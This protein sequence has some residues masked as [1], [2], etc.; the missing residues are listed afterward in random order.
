MTATVLT[1]PAAPTPP[2]QPAPRRAPARSSRL[3]VQRAL[4]T[5][6]VVLIVLVQVYPLV[7]LLL[8]SFRTASDFAGGNPFALPSDL[9]LDNYSRA[10]AT[11]NLGLN[12]LNS[13]I[14]T[15]GA[16]ALIVVAGMMAAFA[17]QVLG[18]RLSGFVRALFLLGI[19]VPVQI[20][21]VP[22]FIDYSR[23][24]LLDTHLSMIIPL[25]AFALPMAVYLFSSFYE[26]I[27]REMYE[28]AS[29]DGAGPYR[30]FGQI[31]LP[32]SLNTI[33]TVVLVNSIFIWNDF[34]FANTFVLSDGLKTIPLGLQNYI[35]AMGNTDWTATFAAVCVTVTPLLLV[36]LV[37][38]KAMIN[39]LESG[40]T[41]G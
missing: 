28:A 27:P 21:L 1:A 3:R 29:L 26:Y 4:L 17:L 35:G 25:A 14:V 40:A 2:A 18:F 31:T 5:A 16:S 20:A 19:I 24:G 7:W 30:I 6:T 34:I 36:F 8:T 13:L 9:T 23:V 10:F 15:L 41:K 37:L 11:G 33:I 39:G 22:L 38:N 32:L 12:V